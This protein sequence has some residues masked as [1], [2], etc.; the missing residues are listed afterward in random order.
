VYTLRLGLHNALQLRGAL[1]GEQ[2]LDLDELSY[3][4]AA[5][6]LRYLVKPGEGFYVP[7]FAIWGGA[8]GRDYGS[9][10]RDSFDYRGGAYVSEPLTTA[11]QVRIEGAY[12]RRDSASR[13]FDLSERSVAASLD[14][15]PASWLT[16]YGE[17]R[18]ADGDIAVTAEGGGIAPKTEH[19]Y[20][21]SYADAIEPDDAFGD[22]WNAFRVPARTRIASFGV[23]VPVGGTFAVDFVVQQVRSKADIAGAPAIGYG[24]GFR[25]DRI[26]GGVSLL[27]RW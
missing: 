3:A 13:V 23:N 9:A 26:V 11:I 27:A 6:R 24:D 14:W 15:A 7:T 8:A 1:D 18:V 2:D 20:L 21:A 17:L 19:L 4:R 12:A 25:Y 10:I 16:L 5:L 22:E